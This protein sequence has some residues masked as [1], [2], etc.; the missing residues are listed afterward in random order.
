MPSKKIVKGARVQGP[1]H[2]YVLPDLVG[3]RDVRES[4]ITETYKMLKRHRGDVATLIPA[5]ERDLERFEV[6][7]DAQLRKTRD[8]AK[9]FVDAY[10]VHDDLPLPKVGEFVSWGDTKP[11]VGKVLALWYL[12]EAGAYGTTVSEAKRESDK[13]S[14]KVSG[15]MSELHRV[16]VAA[17]LTLKR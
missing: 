10:H 7:R 16:G 5:L 8:W 6:K 1:S 15:G 17:C 9:R 2:I 12:L 3:G 13:W 14:H 11:M 4:R